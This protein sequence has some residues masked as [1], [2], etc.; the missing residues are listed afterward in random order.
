VYILGTEIRVR[1]E[2]EL[3]AQHFGERF[4]QYRSNV[5]AYLPG[6]R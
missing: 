1:S 6:L 5:K 2:D 3:L 4:E